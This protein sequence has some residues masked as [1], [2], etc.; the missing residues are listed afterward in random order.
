MHKFT[1]AFSPVLLYIVLRADA[2]RHF[3]ADAVH[4]P[5]NRNN[6]KYITYFKWRK[7]K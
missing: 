3:P 2:V 7:R 1:L 5:E 6:I 4:P